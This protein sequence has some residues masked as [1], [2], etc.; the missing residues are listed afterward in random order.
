MEMSWKKRSHH[1]FEKKISRVISTLCSI[2]DVSGT[3]ISLAQE[4]PILGEA[5]LKK[6]IITLKS[7]RICRLYLI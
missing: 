3:V 5:Y 1:N 4:T 7:A 6:E 2:M